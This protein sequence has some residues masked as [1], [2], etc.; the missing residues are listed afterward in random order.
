M[1]LDQFDWLPKEYRNW[2]LVN[3]NYESCYWKKCIEEERRKMIII[4][5]ENGLRYKYFQL[6]TNLKQIFIL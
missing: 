6:V 4:K 1:F 3:K 5:Y 2:E